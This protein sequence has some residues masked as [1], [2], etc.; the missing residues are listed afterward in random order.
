MIFSGVK[1]VRYLLEKLFKLDIKLFDNFIL[2]LFYFSKSQ[3]QQ[4]RVFLS[5]PY[6]QKGLFKL[7]PG[8]DTFARETIV[9]PPS[10]INESG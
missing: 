9:P 7:V 6:F 2:Y 8:L 5:T 10:I 1:V 3:Q 4:V